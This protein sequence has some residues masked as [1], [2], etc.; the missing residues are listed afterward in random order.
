MV[1]NWVDLIVVILSWRII[2]K[3]FEVGVV[4][5]AIESAVL[6]LIIGLTINFGNILSARISPWIGTDPWA[7][8]CV[9]LLFFLV[10]WLLARVLLRKFWSRKEPARLPRWQQV[11]G[12]TLGLFR[13][14]C[15]AGFL[16]ML[17]AFSEYGL[18]T[19]GVSS[20]ISGRYFAESSR[21]AIVTMADYLPG[22]QFRGKPAIPSAVR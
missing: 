10:L 3:G 12:L 2:Y 15:T 22:A 6:L 13:A 7:D 5:E 11:G 21:T 20:S 1:P 17:L 18:L 9:V 4:S 14:A 8:Y 16:L 19:R